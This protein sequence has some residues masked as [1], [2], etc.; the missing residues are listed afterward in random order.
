M[1][2][3]YKEPR[4][5]NGRGKDKGQTIAGKMVFIVKKKGSKKDKTQMNDGRK[6]ELT[7]FRKSLPILTAPPP[8]QWW[9]K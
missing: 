4:T 5:Q 8:D 7:N 2:G 3:L 1:E 9:A 6:Y